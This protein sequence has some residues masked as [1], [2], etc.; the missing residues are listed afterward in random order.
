MHACRRGAFTLIEVLTVIAIIAL[1]A[2]ILFPVFGRVRENTRQ[3]TCVSNMHEMYVKCSTYQQDFDAYPPLLLGLPERPDGTLWAPGGGAPVQAR[4]LKRGYLYP[5][6]IKN[7]ETFLC[8]DNPT[9]DQQ[10]LVAAGW[11]ANTGHS[12]NATYGSHGNTLAPATT[13]LPFYAFDSY[14]VSSVIGSLSAYQVVYSRDW[15]AAEARGIDTRTDAPNQ[16]KYPSPPAD[17]TTLCW[18]NYH[19]TVASSDK[20]PLVMLSGTA[21]P[22]SA[23]DLAEKSW[24]FASR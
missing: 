5:S 12:G 22:V 13:E 6:Y 18:C 3:T 24:T 1:L 7:S 19:A 21:K 4:D 15:T 20:C 9:K 14:D 16:L 8:P 17:K 11:P 10:K 23:R 2:A